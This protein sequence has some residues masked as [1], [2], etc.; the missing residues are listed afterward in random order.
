MPLKEI[1][2]R[3]FASLNAEHVYPD[4][5]GRYIVL[6]DGYYRDMFYG[7]EAEA[8]EWFKTWKESR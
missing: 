1:A 7:T 4:T 2:R 8:R 3:C 6:V 5:W